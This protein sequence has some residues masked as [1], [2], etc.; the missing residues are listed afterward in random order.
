[1]GFPWSFLPSLPLLVDKRTF[2]TF[3][4]LSLPR[5][6]QAA[7]FCG[8]YHS[9]KT[10]DHINHTSG[11]C[12]YCNLRQESLV[13]LLGALAVFQEK[14]LSIC[15]LSFVNFQSPDMLSVCI[16]YI[17]KFLYL[18]SFLNL[19]YIALFNSSIVAIHILIFFLQRG[20]A[21]LFISPEP[22]FPSMIISIH[23]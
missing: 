12:V 7:G 18:F 11:V 2:V 13:L 3:A 16:F 1:M 20:T 6:Q 5:W 21:Y 17:F 8:Q 22:A 23:L 14:Y 19:E 4:L 15:F 9:G 10:T